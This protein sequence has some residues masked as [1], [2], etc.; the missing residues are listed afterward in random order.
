MISG[1]QCNRVR[2]ITVRIIAGSFV[3]S[4]FEWLTSNLRTDIALFNS[5]LK[6]V[7]DMM[8]MLTGKG[9]V[10]AVSYF[11]VNW[12]GDYGDYEFGLTDFEHIIF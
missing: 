2:L 7:V 9:S 8:F 1:K 6:H 3:Y 4:F 5:R 11:P 10:L 12:N